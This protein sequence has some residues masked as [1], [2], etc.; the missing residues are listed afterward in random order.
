MNDSPSA[1]QTRP[2]TDPASYRDPGSQ[3]F[4][5][6]DTVYRAVDRRT[7]ADFE[8]LRTTRFYAAAT[9]DGRLIESELAEDVDSP[10]GVEWAAVLRHARIPVVSY[11]YEWTF[12]MLR[13]AALLQL[14]LL[15]A[16]ID[17][18]MILKDS[19]PFNVQFRGTQPTF[20]DIGSF[21]R[22]APGD[23]WVGYR[24]FLRQYLYPLMMTAHVG[25]PFQPWLRGQPEGPTAEEMRRMLSGRDLLRKSTLLHVALLSRAEKRYDDEGTARDVRSELKEAGFTKEMTSANVESLRR[26]VE[27]LRWDPGVSAWNEYSSACGHVGLQRD[28]KADFVTQSLLE[29]APKVVWDVGTNDGHFARLAAVTSDY[30]LALDSDHL[31]LDQLYRGLRQDGV[32]NVLPLIQDLA[33]PSPGLGWRGAERPPLTQRSSPDLVLCLAVL[34]HLVIGRNVP[35]RAV[36]DWL[37]DLGSHVVLEFVPPDD[38]MVQKLTAN[39]RPH[40]VH[41]DYSEEALRRYVADRFDLRREA[42]VPAGGR[43]LFALTP[44]T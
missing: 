37:A 38:P 34:H 28:F 21:E 35:L 6:G 29:D 27:Q 17:E 13:D 9:T 26:V 14:D 1:E 39:K 24:Q 5:R 11:P 8:R 7:L 23:V 22:L 19:T 16:A 41:R 25:I 2:E 33:D 31:V 44:R 40:E 10:P 30:V 32:R 3:V 36:I 12:S 20:I 18:D 15:S 42:T 43:Q 4:H